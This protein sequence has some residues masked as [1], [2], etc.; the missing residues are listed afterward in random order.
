LVVRDLAQPLCRLAVGDVIKL[1]RF[2]FRV[3]ALVAT[4]GDDV[5]KLPSGGSRT[6]VPFV[7]PSEAP[8]K[9]CR[10]CLMEGEEG[11]DADPLIAPCACK[12]SIEHVHVG[13]L[14]HWL[15]SK[16]SASA[17][18]GNSFRYATPQCELCK[19]CLPADVGDASDRRPLVELPRTEP[20]FLVLESHNHGDV[21]QMTH[22]VSLASEKVLRI[23]RSQD[24]H[25]RIDDVSVSRTH[26][27]IA[28]ENG[29]FVIADNNAK[30]G[31]LLALRQDQRVAP[32][33]TLSI[34]SGRTVL[35]FSMPEDDTA[36][37]GGSA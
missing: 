31:T 32:G 13:C 23:G 18:N 4:G 21:Q 27:T 14:Q 16:V 7:E 3:K 8:S 28:F 25:V 11:P 5:P 12:G 6:A 22:V 19:T 1:G 9:V 10:I 20:P 15:R 34:Q 17:G 29:E 24:S 30:F 36:S 33:S 35:K 2:E 37:I 26:S